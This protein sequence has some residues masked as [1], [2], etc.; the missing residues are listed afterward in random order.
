MKIKLTIS[1]NGKNYVGWQKQNN[2]KSVQEEIE[3]ALLILLGEKVEVFASGRTDAGVHAICQVAHFESNSEKL[4]TNFAKKNKSSCFEKL[5]V[6]LNAN[7]PSDI[8]VEKANKVRKNFHARF[9]VKKKTYE[10]LMSWKQTPFNLGL[11]GLFRKKPCIEAMKNASRFLIGTHNFS[12]F[13]SSKTQAKDFI[14][15]IYKINITKKTNCIKI[16]ICGNGFL[17]NMVRIIVGTLYDVGIGKI[18][19]EKIKEILEKKNR[20]YAGETAPAEG[21]YLKKVKY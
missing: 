15:T 5:V 12:S 21:L 19:P 2:G 17:Y 11:V 10:Y 4:E 6:A 16:E 3:N 7:L 9:D 13:A 18:Q 8:R 1:Y 20:I 14:R